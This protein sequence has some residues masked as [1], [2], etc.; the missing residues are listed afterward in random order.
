MPTTLPATNKDVVLNQIEKLGEVL[1]RSISANRYESAQ[2]CSARLLA[3]HSWE[4]HAPIQ[5]ILERARRTAILQRS[6]AWS[7]L[8]DLQRAN[9]YASGMQQSSHCVGRG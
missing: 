7:R 5:A 4:T 2:E 3:L 1:I 6:T 9:Q 8:A